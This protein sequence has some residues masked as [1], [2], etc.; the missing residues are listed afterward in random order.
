MGEKVHIAD[1]CKTIQRSPIREIFEMAERMTGLVRLETGEPDFRT[2]PPIVDA[3]KAALERE[4]NKYTSAAGILSLR[5]TIAEKYLR[6]HNIKADPDTEVMIPTGGASA[7]HLTLLATINPGDEVLIPDP[8]W[9]QYIQLVR[10]AGGV[11]VYYSI[12]NEANNNYDFSLDPEKVKEKIT[13][14]TKAII[15][16]FPSN[17]TG[18]VLRKEECQALA[19]I[20]KEKDLLLISDEVYEQLI[21]DDYEH[22]CAAALPDMFERTIVFGS[23]SKTYSMTGWRVGYALGPKDIIS[24]MVKFQSLVTICPN[25]SAQMAYSDAIKGAGDWVSKMVG[26]Y[27][28]R[29]DFLVN[30][31]NEIPGINCKKP[32]GTFYVFPNIAGTGI[33][34][35]EFSRLLLEK[36]KVTSVPGLGFG[37]DGGKG[38]VRFSYANSIEEIKLALERIQLFA[39]SLNKG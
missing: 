17:P 1:R 18:A 16:N 5:E 35:M 19:D 34:E 37:P 28:N 9:P 12:R 2:P 26:E 7:V 11:P 39:E 13:S 23:A 15:I 29:R 27:R 24:E 31:L 36:F 21:Y 14:K 38:Y 6:E 25:A 20:V 8:G 30:G 4:E 22:I 3:G 33:T 32:L 10:H